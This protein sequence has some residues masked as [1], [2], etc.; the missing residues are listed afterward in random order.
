MRHLSTV[1][2]L[3]A[4]LGL[5]YTGGEARADAELTVRSADQ[6]LH[7][8][9]AI[10]ASQIPG[11]LLADAQ[12]VAIIPGVIKV[13]FIA[14][15]RRGHGVVMVR[16]PEGAW[17]L[18]Q[19]VTLTGGSVGWQAGVQGTDV[20]LVFMTQKERRRSDD[21]QVHDRRGCRGRRRAGR[22]QRR[23]GHRWSLEGRDSFLFAQ[24]RIVCRHLAGRI[25]DR[26]QLGRADQLLRRASWTTGGAR[27]GIGDQARAGPDLADSWQP[28]RA[29]R[30][31]GSDRRRERTSRQLVK[32]WDKMRRGCLASSMSRGAST[33]PCP[34]KSSRAT[35]RPRSMPCRLRSSSTTWWPALPSIRHW[36]IARSF[37]PRAIRCASM[38]ANYRPMRIP[39][40]AL[41]PPPITR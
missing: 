19:F 33:W 13:G 39:Q 10:P 29:A 28:N 17:G 36:P 15:I 35:P 30:D 5:A 40:L 2:L 22:T 18:P 3:C 1:A 12:G 8:I 21:R 9:M 16:G 20:V 26:G 14:G 23:R 32:R 31:S 7:E 6:T 11:T 24:P 34:R 37:R 41:P 38:S 27:A 4:I 25:G